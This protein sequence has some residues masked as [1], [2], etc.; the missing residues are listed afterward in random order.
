MPEK[1]RA[2]L[3]AEE[4][5]LPKEAPS[6]RKMETPSPALSP[7]S[8][9]SAAPQGSVPSELRKGTS[10]LWKRSPN[11]L[12]LYGYITIPAQSDITPDGAQHTDI[13]RPSGP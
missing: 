4:Q 7:G 12:V 13:T 6:C 3:Q 1:H 10:R 11:G 9:C 8:H 2:R 5:S